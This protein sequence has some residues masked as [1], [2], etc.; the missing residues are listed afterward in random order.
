MGY[1]FRLGRRSYEK[2]QTRAAFVLLAPTMVAL[3]LLFL[4]PVIQVVVLSFTNMNT[5]TGVSAFTGLSNY[6]YLL[7]NRKFHDAMKNTVVFTLVKL[8]AEVVLSFFIAVMLD[9]HIPLRKY[10]RISF[11]APVVVPVVASSIIWI[12][13]FDPTIGPFNQVLIALG[14]EPLQWIYHES[15][16]LMSIA[17]FSVWRGIGYDVIV[18]LAGLQSIPD[19][20]VEAARV[21]G[22]GSWQ[23]MRRIKIPLMAPVISFVVMM[24]FIGSFQVFTEVDVMTP[25]GGPGGSTTLFV[26]Y[27]YQ[28]AFGNSRMGRGAAASLVLFLIIF[29]LTC[30]QRAC[31]G[32]DRHAY[33]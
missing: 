3:V 21:D 6:E 27:I 15:S 29:A 13:F 22:A 31:G 17:L 1:R 4:V 12:W 25:E 24:G 33:D 20:Y 23:I 5:S 28:Q 9:T 2:E 18:F 32:K 14:L 11:F 26:N 16:A 7:A 10:L 8:T 19:S 30:V